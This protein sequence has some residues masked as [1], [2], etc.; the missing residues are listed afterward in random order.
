MVAAHNKGNIK[1]SNA[2]LFVYNENGQSTTELDL[3]V[4]L[5]LSA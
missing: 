1:V 5:F 2:R 4:S 3:N